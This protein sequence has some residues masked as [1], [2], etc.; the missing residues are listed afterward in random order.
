MVESFFSLVPV[1]REEYKSD[2]IRET[3]DYY[4]SVAVIKKGTLPN[5]FN[6]HDLRGAKACF[7]KVSVIKKQLFKWFDQ[8]TSDI[9]QKDYLYR[10]SLQVGSLAGWTLPIHKLIAN[11]VMKIEV[12]KDLCISLNFHEFCH[13]LQMIKL[14]YE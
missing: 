6:M 1:L 11:D 2:G 9:L 13:V 3:S 12:V 14:K 10:I 7:P 8:N 5:V 4:H